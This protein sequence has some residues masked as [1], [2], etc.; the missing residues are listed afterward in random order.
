MRRFFRFYFGGRWSK[1]FR[2]ILRE[3]GRVI[4]RDVFSVRRRKL[5]DAVIGLF[6]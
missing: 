4:R 1:S 2:Y 5:N 6:V 3:G